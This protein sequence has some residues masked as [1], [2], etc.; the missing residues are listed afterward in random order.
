MKI[1]FVTHS[2][3]NYVPDL[4][5][6]GLRKLMGPDVV[7][8][9][10]K[11]CLY[12]GV[13]GLG[14]CPPDQRC[15]GW[16]PDDSD[17]I[18]R[19]DIWRKV[20]AGYF[21]LVVCDLR[22]LN[23]M[24]AHLQAWP[25]HCVVIDGEDAPHPLAPGPYVICRRETDGSDFS[26]PLP[27]ALPEEIYHWISRY[28]GLT[29]DFSIGFLGSTHN[30]NRKQFV[31]ALHS[32]FPDALLNATEIPSSDQP[33]PAGRLGRDAY[34]RQ[35]QQ[36]RM[37]L[38]LTGA[39][40]DTF[41]FWEHAA[42]NAVHLSARVPLYIPGDFIDDIEITRFG[43]MDELRRKIDA[44]ASDASRC[45]ER[46]ARSRS[47]LLARHLTTHR[48]SYFLDRVS[49][50]L[51]RDFRIHWTAA[52]SPGSGGREA[53]ADP[54][55][56]G[57]SRLYLG[58]VKGE[59]YGWGVCSRYLIDELSR[60]RPVHVLTDR[61][62]SAHQSRIDGKLFQ[63]LTGVDLRPLFDGTRGAQNYGYTFFENE[64]TSES[65]KNAKQFDLILAGSTWCRDRMTERGILNCDILI[66]GI[67]PTLFNP[68]E[69]PP[70]DD[71]FVIF[72][73]GKFELRKG[74]D[75][76]LRAVKILQDKY[77]D[78]YLVNCWYN[79]W[80]ESVRQMAGSPY[81]SFEHRDK[82]SWT[83]TMLR[84]YVQNGLD[85]ERI[86]TMELVPHHQLRSL[87]KQTHVGVFPNRCEGGTNLVLM[88]Y[89]ACAKPAVASFTSG[90]MDILT[91]TN[92][93]LLRRQ[94][95]LDV[96]CDDGTLI[97]RW[98]E[99]SLEELVEKLE[100]AYHHR[101]TLEA[102]GRQAGQEMRRYTWRHCARR[103][104]RIIGN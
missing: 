47:K 35:L 72:S 14:V 34:Y 36:C 87:F 84:T 51:S 53:A 77:P 29:K 81:I 85:P 26:I 38:S 56:G 61:N 54:P 41:R 21:D 49:A 3:P 78:V 18:D 67:D 79:L 33:V 48:A 6:H 93:I 95:D 24:T 58:L 43:A 28:D 19:W 40:M 75:L 13:L 15:P 12:E 64:L 50:A 91:D 20:R 16:F 27:M 5:L 69:A 88:E 62:A 30:D 98:Q 1:L 52:A 94:K 74:Q 9:P 102:I 4:L 82:E 65:L 31:E 101:D 25:R 80:P 44:I 70:P 86:A 68:I 92:A 57:G 42:C 32:A 76:V 45:A 10:R 89:M 7:D 11:D 23:E 2:Y 37:V 99:P 60:I 83:D 22:A 39:G 103:L 17:T 90:H 55:A 63:A 96:C 97:G 66:Q 8:Y 104:A 71:R 100:S 59:N 73:G 46:I